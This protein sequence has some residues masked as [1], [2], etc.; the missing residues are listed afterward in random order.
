MTTQT[1][2]GKEPLH[3]LLKAPIARVEDYVLIL[4]VSAP[5]PSVSCTERSSPQEIYKVESIHSTGAHTADAMDMLHGLLESIDEQGSVADNLS[6]VMELGNQIEGLNENLVR[7]DRRYIHDGQIKISP[8]GAK[9]PVADYVYLFNDVLI[10]C[11][12]SGKTT[13]YVGR[14]YMHRVQLV[15]SADKEASDILLVVDERNK[16]TLAVSDTYERREWAVMLRKVIREVERTR[17]VFGIPL[18]TL[19]KREL[20]MDIPPIVEK[21]IHFIYEYGSDTVGIFRQT[22]RA[23]QIEKLKD[24][25][26]QGGN[27]FFSEDMDV[28]SVAALFKLWLREMPEPLFTWEAYEKF[29]ATVVIEDKEEQLKTLKEVM[30][31]LPSINLNTTQHMFKCL[32]AI[33]D[34]E[35]KT[36]MNPGNLAVVFAPNILKNP[37]PNA[38]PFDQ[39]YYTNINVI[40]VAVSLPLRDLIV[41]NR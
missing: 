35:E 1:A 10:Y 33:C 9:K 18:S 31:T 12:T 13:N 30:R 40:F 5:L 24:Q 19:M 6:K 14:F 7:P 22:G 26:N 39:S 20:E 32:R 29:M 25:L 36:K 21:T 2:V 41:A 15:D 27:V 37:D 23:T 28:H 11:Q 38:D 4:T 3:E 8:Q 16:F 17:K 34:N